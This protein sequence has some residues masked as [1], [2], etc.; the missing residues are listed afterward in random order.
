V[1][2]APDRHLP[3]RMGVWRAMTDYDNYIPPGEFSCRADFPP[4]WPG[5]SLPAS[6]KLPLLTCRRNQSSPRPLCRVSGQETTPP[7]PSPKFPVREA[8]QA[9]VARGFLL[10]PIRNKGA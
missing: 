5:G 10:P 6:A 7:I 9:S 2:L 4:P 8:P 1:W 3:Q